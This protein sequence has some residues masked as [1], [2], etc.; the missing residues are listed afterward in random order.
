M[1]DQPDNDRIP[2][3][4]EAIERL[5]L[6]VVDGHPHEA[7]IRTALEHGADLV[8]ELPDEDTE[9]VLVYVAGPDGQLGDPIGSFPASMASP[10]QN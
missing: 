10:S 3:E 7:T 5:A 4:A 1:T 6:S 8:A 9:D 2:L